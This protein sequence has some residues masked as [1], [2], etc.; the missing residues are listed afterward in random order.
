MAMTKKEKE[1]VEQ[2][3]HEV[4]LKAALRWT[5]KVLPDLP[6]PKYGDKD[7]SGWTFNSYNGEVRQSWSS[8]VAH[9][10]GAS[11]SVGFGA[12]QNSIAMY[13]TKILA[14][15]AMRFEMENKFARDL[16]KVDL[17]IKKESK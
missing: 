9:G 10:S 6:H 3:E 15:K 1:Y 12:S 8:T 4:R 5:D 2:L 13:S 16:A 14:L 11:R 17:E 7:T